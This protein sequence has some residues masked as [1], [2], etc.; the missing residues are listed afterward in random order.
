M[1]DESDLLLDYTNFTVYNPDTNTLGSLDTAESGS[2]NAIDRYEFYYAAS[3][4]WLAPRKCNS[5]NA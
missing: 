3:D 1:A 2:L 4:T 5:K